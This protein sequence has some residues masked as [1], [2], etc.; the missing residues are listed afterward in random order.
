MKLVI[1]S[2]LATLSVAAPAAAQAPP[3]EGAPQTVLP[4]IPSTSVGGNLDAR[5]D[6]TYLEDAE[7]T[8]LNVDV[9][10]Q[11]LTPTGLGGYVALPLAYAHSDSGL[12]G[13]DDSSGIGNLE[14]GGMYVSRNSP[15]LDVFVRGGFAIDTAGDETALFAPISR[16]VPMPAD[17]FA[18]GLDTSW[19]RLGGGLRSRGPVQFGGHVGVD[20]PLDDLGGADGIVSVTGAIGFQQP[21]FGLS[22]SLTYV[23]IFG[24]DG[25]GGNDD[26]F[27]LNATADFPIGPTA[28][29][30]AA[31]GANLDEFDD[32]LGISLGGGVRAR[33]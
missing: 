27:G 7:I 30:F 6:Y 19:A 32:Q 9:R 24:E 13:D 17:A 33:L 3:P 2:C 20:L 31:F 28:S 26:T 22:G 10:Y 11:Y 14:L 4:G 29:M 16:L 12:I 25:G 15:E 23:N 5:L 8:L 21:G 1:A 18:S